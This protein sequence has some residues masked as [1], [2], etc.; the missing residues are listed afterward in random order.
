MLSLLAKVIKSHNHVLICGYI[1]YVN[2]YLSSK[3]YYIDT[4][5]VED[6]RKTFENAINYIDHCKF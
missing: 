4:E 5:K 1:T 6:L 3:S 2:V